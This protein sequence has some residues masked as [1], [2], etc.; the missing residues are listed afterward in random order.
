MP[1]HAP[2]WNPPFRPHARLTG[3]TPFLCLYVWTRD[4]AAAAEMLV[5]RDWADIETAP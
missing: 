2:V 5:S 1:A 3:R 4:V